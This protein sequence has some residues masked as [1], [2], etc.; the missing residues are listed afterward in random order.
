MFLS[1]VLMM[2]EYDLSSM[3]F[4]NFVLLEKLGICVAC[5]LRTGERGSVWRINY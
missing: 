2:R 4:R 1:E 3:L 5:V